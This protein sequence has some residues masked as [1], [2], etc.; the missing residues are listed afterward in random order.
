MFEN[1]CSKKGE[2][3]VLYIKMC[4]E[5][6]DSLSKRQFLK[7]T[8]I[9]YRLLNVAMDVDDVFL[10]WNISRMQHEVMAFQLKKH[11]LEDVGKGK[12]ILLDKT[13]WL[14]GEKESMTHFEKC[15][16]VGF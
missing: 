5:N 14:T 15:D 6:R 2:V 13:P 7:M 3:A 9:C 8:Q 1:R 10:K 4:I 11:L 12:L 16:T